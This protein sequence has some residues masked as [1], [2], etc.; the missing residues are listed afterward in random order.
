MLPAPPEAHRPN[1]RFPGLPAPRPWEAP[2][3]SAQVGWASGSFRLLRAFRLLAGLTPC[4]LTGNPQGETPIFPGAALLRGFCKVVNL[5]GPTQFH[6]GSWLRQNPEGWLWASWERGWGVGHGALWRALPTDPRG[7]SCTGHTESITVSD[8]T[9]MVP[10][11]ACTG[12]FSSGNESRFELSCVHP[13]WSCVLTWRKACRGS[14]WGAGLGCSWP[15]GGW[16]PQHG[17]GSLS[18][19]L[20]GHGCEAGRSPLL[21]PPLTGLHGSGVQGLGLHCMLDHG[22]PPGLGPAMS[23]GCCPR[24]GGSALNAPGRRAGAR[25]GA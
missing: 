15:S 25:G 22:V 16:S 10:K 13:H 19:A 8:G 2:P 21:T 5:C 12:P 14:G 9:L 7:H 20:S 17:P 4:A 11:A 24:G 1:P 18:G 3:P 23:A 6:C